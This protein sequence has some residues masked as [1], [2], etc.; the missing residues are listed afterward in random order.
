MAEAAAQTLFTAGLQV[1]NFLYEGNPKEILVHESTD[2]KAD[3]LFLGA[4][5]LHHGGRLSLGTVASAV[6][7]RAR[8]SVELV[9]TPSRLPSQL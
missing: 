9:R 1:T 4:R 6:A 8:C 3:T 7:T 5:G 2:W